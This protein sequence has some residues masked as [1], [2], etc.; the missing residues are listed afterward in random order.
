MAQSQGDTNEAPLDVA[1]L[2]AWTPESVRNA[3]RKIEQMNLT[4]DYRSIL[5]RLAFDARMEKV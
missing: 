1:T 3:I 4:I 5:H 2:P